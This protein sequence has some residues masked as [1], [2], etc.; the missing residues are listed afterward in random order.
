MAYLDF[1][2]I[3]KN[4]IERREYQVNIAKAVLE[5]GNTL[6]VA[7]TALGKTVI[8]SIVIASRLRRGKALFLAP[9]KPLAQQHQ[10][11]LK[12]ILDIDEAEI[13]LLTGEVR[14]EERKKIW[15]KARVVSATP[16]TI[17]NDLEENRI[18]LKD[19]S[20]VVF[21]EAHRA[22]GDYAYTYIGERY[23][24]EARHPL[25]L[26][27]TASPGAN[28]NKI[29]EVKKNL[30]IKHIEIRTESD[31]DVE[32]YI[33]K[34]KL[35]WRKSELNPELLS[36][37][38]LLEEFL[39]E[40]SKALKDAGL[41][42]RTLRG[43]PLK[44]QLI[45]LQNELARKTSE[46]PSAYHFISVLASL[47]KVQHALELCQ[48]QGVSQTLNF[49]SKLRYEKSRASRS[50]L[51][52]PAIQ[53]A[54]VELS[55]L[56]KRGVEH[57]K[58]LMLLG[59]VEKSVRN[60]E[61]VIVFAHYRETA[62]YLKELI[63]SRGIRAEKFIGQATRNKDKGLSQKE[64]KALIKRFREGEFPVI[65]M[66]SIGEE[67][68]DIPSVD[69]VIFYEPVP[70]EIRLIQRK[71]RTGRKH[72]GKV[73]VLMT[74]K[75]ADEAYYWASRNKE[76]RM[77]KILQKMSNRIE[78][79]KDSQTTLDNYVEG[80]P[81]ELSVFVDYREAPSGI[82]RAL[83]DEGIRVKQHA[84]KVGDY[85]IS[86]RIVIE[87]KSASD[88]VQ[89]II[90]GR[91]FK[92]VR[93]MREQFELPVI[94]VEGDIYEHE[95]KVND[96]ALR[97]ALVS[98]IVKHGVALL[99]SRSIVETAKF[100]ALLAKQEKEEGSSP[101]LRGEKPKASISEWQK[102][103]VSSLPNVGPK[104][105]EELLKRFG[106]V[107]AVF[108]ATERELRRVR[109]LGEKKAKR[110]RQLLLTEFRE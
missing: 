35:F 106:S 95:R 54:I 50:I 9:T 3:K 39:R 108:N 98:L 96:N 47:I 51:S 21:D 18:S 29:N 40:K 92:Q 104:A 103:I 78:I 75:T 42:I 72:E 102:Y 31:P 57:P 38:R 62:Q 110:I 44:K 65:I 69:H 52:H 16:Q 87:R 45:S 10:H 53:Q 93:L 11:S 6:V 94:I 70:S 86:D 85:I 68:L 34:K 8:A 80:S 48:T 107:S 61:S 63:N 76:E 88:F 26:A 91:L 30:G 20:I 67:G 23:L 27:L 32:P 5:K 100:I 36:V 73:T 58:V 66:T 15:E 33:H 49:L 43:L 41:K 24:K 82:I 74:E 22:V 46:N 109:G 2:N 59:E 56:K 37:A 97:G 77:Y 4:T 89:S 101:H 90:D 99:F 64:Q 1:P 84:L 19:V 14:A 71:G 81:E 60:N 7:P 28:R 105:A 12:E 55:D 13:V 25:I 83:V 17:A 79:K